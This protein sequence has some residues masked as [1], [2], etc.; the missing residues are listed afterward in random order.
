[1]RKL[2]CDPEQ[3]VT[4]S[5]RTVEFVQN[6][7]TRQHPA[8]WN[9][10]P[11]VGYFCAGY[12]SVNPIINIYLLKRWVMKCCAHY[13]L[14]LA[15]IASANCF[16]FYLPITSP[17]SHPANQL[18]PPHLAGASLVKFDNNAASRLAVITTSL[19][20]TSPNSKRQTQP[21]CWSPQLQFEAYTLISTSIILF[22]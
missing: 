12:K 13:E 9:V 2:T 19:F 18:K 1:M 3:K 5:H 15:G 16:F 22:R 14:F 17:D 11:T 4:I 20:N 7:R 10:W 8:L 6:G 21:Y